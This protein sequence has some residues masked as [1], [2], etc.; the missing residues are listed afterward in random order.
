MFKEFQRNSTEIDRKKLTI[1]PNMVTVGILYVEVHYQVPSVTQ[2]DRRR[3]L[4]V[5]FLFVVAM[6]YHAMDMT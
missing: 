2:K 1:C 3:L 5:L 6:P 4:S